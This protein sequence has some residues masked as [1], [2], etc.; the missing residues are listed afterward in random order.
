MKDFAERVEFFNP[1]TVQK[2]RTL[3]RPYCMRTHTEVCAP[4]EVMKTNIRS[5]FW[6]KS[7]VIFISHTTSTKLGWKKI[8]LTIFLRKKVEGGEKNAKK[9]QKRRF[10]RGFETISRHYGQNCTKK[11]L[12]APVLDG[13]QWN[14]EKTGWKNLFLNGF[15]GQNRRKMAEKCFFSQFFQFGGALLRNESS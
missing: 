11:I 3:I 10:F 2:S 6:S 5:K 8:F 13:F 1:Q 12:N 9:R 4:V 15:Y 14:L 7:I